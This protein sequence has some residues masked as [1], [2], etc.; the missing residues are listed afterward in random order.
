MKLLPFALLQIDLISEGQQK[1]GT[2]ET[3]QWENIDT[4][5][6]ILAW[7]SVGM[8]MCIGV[9]VHVQHMY[10]NLSKLCVFSEKE[11]FDTSNISMNCHPDSCSKTFF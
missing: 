9:H 4:P 3:R 1:G 7:G 5:L 8:H 6:F 10:T 11:N 2:F